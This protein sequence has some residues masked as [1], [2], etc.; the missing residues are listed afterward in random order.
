MWGASQLLSQQDAAEF[1]GRNQAESDVN[2]FL[3]L[4]FMRPDCQSAKSCNMLKHL[5]FGGCLS[6]A[7]LLLFVFGCS[8]Y[9]DCNKQGRC[10]WNG[11]S[12]E[13]RVCS[14]AA[15][16]RAGCEMK[17]HSIATCAVRYKTWWCNRKPD[18][19]ELQRRLFVG[20]LQSPDSVEPGSFG[21]TRL[22]PN[23]Y[24][25]RQKLCGFA[26]IYLFVFLL[27]SMC[28]FGCARQHTEVESGNQAALNFYKRLG[29][30]AHALLLQAACAT[31]LQMSTCRPIC[32]RGC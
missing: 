3:G 25:N 2:P 26:R 15:A 13:R 1:E 27:S 14:S 10:S 7:C 24:S 19:G 23:Y 12:Q 6:Q 28:T 16:S 18:E 29:F 9:G 21:C 22:D 17:H 4:G 32:C 11:T 30:Q 8:T 20:V 5:S 31:Y